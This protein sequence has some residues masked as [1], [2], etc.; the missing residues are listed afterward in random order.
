MRPT[1]RPRAVH[2]A[3]TVVSAVLVLAGGLQAVP[4]QAADAETGSSGPSADEGARGKAFWEDDALPAVTAEE[5]ASKQAVASGKPIEVG[6]VT[7]ATSKVVANPD[8]TFTAE[9][10]TSPSGSSAGARR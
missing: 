2:G 6:G 4:V 5:K 1:S 9:T 8:G 7:S 3:M 10:T